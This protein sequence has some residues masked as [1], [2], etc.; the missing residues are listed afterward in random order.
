MDLKAYMTSGALEL[1]VLGL[2]S[3]KESREVESLAEKHPELQKEIDTIRKALD[4]YA[5]LHGVYPPDEVKTKLESQLNGGFDEPVPITVYSQ[6]SNEVAHLPKFRMIRVHWFA[7]LAAFASVIAIGMGVLAFDYHNRLDAITLAKADLEE[8]LERASSENLQLKKAHFA[9]SEQ[10][11]FISSLET[12]QVTLNATRKA[13]DAV[14]IIYWNTDQE[15]AFLQWKQLPELLDG[16]RYRLWAVAR[17]NF[18]PLANMNSK[19]SP[20]ATLQQIVFVP[21]VTSFIV[22]LEKLNGPDY[23]DLSRMYLQGSLN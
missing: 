12:R 11:S 8:G 2:S 20:A 1:Y 7:M 19:E 13:N 18:E 6:K 14:V 16:M 15:R 22:T 9:L 10:F 4:E 17:R 5:K 3:E 23:P 21:G